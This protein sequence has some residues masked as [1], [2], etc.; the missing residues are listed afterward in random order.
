MEHDT[1]VLP[2]ELQAPPVETAGPPPSRGAGG[3]LKGVGV[4]ATGLVA[5]AI[6]VAVLQG[7]PSTAATSPA[8]STA[9]NVPP[10]AQGL[11][12]RPNRLGQGLGGPGTGGPGGGVAGESR[13]VGTIASVGAASI[14]VRTAAGTSVTVPVNGATEIALNGALVS[15]AELKGGDQVLVHVIPAGTGTV[16]ERILAGNA[17]GPGPGGPPAGKQAPASGA[18]STT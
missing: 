5:G 15:L 10:G 9:Q 17:A 4:V 8:A 6:G 14:T 13:L 18:T 11:P 12:G 7:S 16:A 2:E 3:V 1:A